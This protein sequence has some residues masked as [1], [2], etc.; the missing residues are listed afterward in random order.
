MKGWKKY[1][2][3]MLVVSTLPFISVHCKFSKSKQQ[4]LSKLDS[5]TRDSSKPAY[6]PYKA[7]QGTATYDQQREVLGNLDSV[8]TP[9]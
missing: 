1:F 4:E 5:L 3:L 6:N 2:T 7:G 8:A 9:H